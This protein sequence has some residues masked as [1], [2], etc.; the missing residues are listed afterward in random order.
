MAFPAWVPPGGPGYE[1]E[2]TRPGWDEN[3]RS[4]SSPDT[5]SSFL[6]GVRNQFGSMVPQGQLQEPATDWQ[7]RFKELQSKSGSGVLHQLHQQQQQQ[8]NQPFHQTPQKPPQAY[9]SQQSQPPPQPQPPYMQPPQMQQPLP[10][11]QPQPPPQHMHQPSVSEEAAPYSPANTRMLLTEEEFQCN[12][13]I[14]FGSGISMNGCTI[15]R[16]LNDGDPMPKLEPLSS[17][18]SLRIT[19]TSIIFLHHYDRNPVLEVPIS[20][21]YE[22]IENYTTK[23]W[24]ACCLN[25]I[26]TSCYTHA[27]PTAPH[28]WN[29][30]APHPANVLPSTRHWGSVRMR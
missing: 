10:H 9:P 12:S 25:N 21:L 3:V 23:V 14:E 4:G 30:S 20:E 28:F 17:S 29:L 27:T 13:A 16:H 15:D 11:Y 18:V 8:M 19:P 26:R 5:A 6:Q 24:C 7:A 2:P 22:V 1:P